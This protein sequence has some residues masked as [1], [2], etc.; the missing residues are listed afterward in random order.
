MNEKVIEYSPGSNK[1]LVDRVDGDAMMSGTLQDLATR[2]QNYV[3][4]V[5]SV[6]PINQRHDYVKHVHYLREGVFSKVTI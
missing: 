2:M 1:L 4:R 3:I 6:N 5:L